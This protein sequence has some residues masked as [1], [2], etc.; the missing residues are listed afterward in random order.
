[1]KLLSK[2][3]AEALRRQGQE[4]TGANGGPIQMQFSATDAAL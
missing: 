2:W 1:M 3:D 4:H